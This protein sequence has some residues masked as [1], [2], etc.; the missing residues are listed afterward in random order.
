[1]KIARTYREVKFPE[2]VIRLGLAS[3]IRRLPPDTPFSF[4][5]LLVTHTPDTL[6]F[7]NEDDFFAEYAN[8]EVRSAILTEHYGDFEFGAQFISGFEFQ[9]TVQLAERDSVQEVLRVFDEA[10]NEY[11]LAASGSESSVG[12]A[13]AKPSKPSAIVSR[14]KTWRPPLIV[15][16][17]NLKSL[18]TFLS[19]GGASVS[20]R[21]RRRDGAEVELPSNEFEYENP[22]D[23]EL[24]GVTL[25]A[26]SPFPERKSVRL[27][28]ESPG[29]FEG[30]NTARF[31]ME[32][33]QSEA[34]DTFRRLVNELK[35]MR[36]WYAPFFYLADPFFNIWPIIT[37]AVFAIV[38]TALQARDHGS[39]FLPALLY[40]LLAGL[41]LRAFILPLVLP[42][43]SFA[44]GQG[45]KLHDDR[46]KLAGTIVAVFG[47]LAVLA[48]SL[49]PTR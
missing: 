47:V 3:F 49:T 10:A 8:D 36:A 17:S 15:R 6:S 45:A 5:S 32:V 14:S 34:E 33:P 16:E 39:F 1:M 26:Q 29:I 23:A 37:T 35:A 27:T 48:V 46:V 21:T 42:L 30:G 2:Q 11:K 38:L 25:V 20:F 12:T 40:C 19:A 41:F 31:T 24:S 4:A 9:V 44:V 28:L 18:M 43:V 7:D 13:S 22:W